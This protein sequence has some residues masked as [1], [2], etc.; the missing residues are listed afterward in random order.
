[1]FGYITVCQ[2]ELK[3]K[4]FD[5]YR[6]YYCGLCHALKKQYGRTGQM[7]LNY[8]MTFLAILLSALYEAEE[9]TVK[10]RCIPHPVRKH[11][12]RFC[13][14]TRYAADMTVLLAREKALDDWTDEK[15]L[16]SR[17]L[18]LLLEGGAGKAGDHWIR[19]RNSLRE[20]LAGLKLDEQKEEYDI[21]RMAGY[22]GR[23]L[24]EI[25]VW[26]EDVWEPHL[27]RLGYYLG[28]FIYLRDAWEDREKDRKK[29]NYNLFLAGAKHG[30][31]Y[32]REQVQDMLTDT[33][34]HACAAF[35]RL[36]VIRCGEILRNI[37]YAGV[38]NGF[39]ATEDARI[40]VK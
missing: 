31:N 20:N 38:W 28:K 16:P 2:K 5:L 17:V 12:E 26:K 36:P 22:T 34:A 4:D 13:D 23:F 18:A 24:G 11:E 3:I 7:L 35:E 8:D 33:M 1:M 27:R 9:E 30:K 25:F 15:K 32:S 19:Q 21:D 14:V 40:E 37:L 6:S 10:A 39:A 29:E